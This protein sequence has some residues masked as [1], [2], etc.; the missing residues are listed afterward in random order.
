MAFIPS[1]AWVLMGCLSSIAGASNLSSL[2]PPLWEESPGQ[3][4]DYEV[5]N[6]IYI[7]DPWVYTKRIGM[8][9]ILLNQTATYFAKF[10]PENEQN[11]L[12]GL[13]LQHGWQFRSGRLADP[14]R[15]TN[16]G[17][18]PDH[19]LCISVDSWWADLNYFLCAIP[20]LAAVD[21][22][23]IGISADQVTLVP[24][25]KD[26]LRFCYNV[27]DCRSSHPEMMNNW[28]A[29]YQYLKSP[30]TNFDD[31]LK[32]IWHAHT[33]S[34]EGALGDFEDRFLYYSIPEANFEKSWVLIVNYLAAALY[35]ATLVRT[36]DFQKVLPPQ[37][38][39]TMDIAPFIKDFT[40]IQNV[41]LY[42]LTMFKEVNES[43]GFSN[44]SDLYPSRWKES[45]TDFSDYSVQNGI[46]VIDAWLFTSRLGL[47]K[48]LLNKTAKYFTKFAP[49]NE[50][51][52]LWGLPLQLDWQ[53]KTGRLVDPT[54][55]AN[56]VHGPEDLC[57]SVDSWWAVQ[58]IQSPSS[59]FTLILKYLWA[60]HISSLKNSA[61]FFEDRYAHYSNQEA[62]FMKNWLIAVDYLALVRFPTT[63]I[64]TREFQKH[65][66]PRILVS[67]DSAIFIKDFTATQ[68][69]VLVVLSALGK[70]ERITGL[71]DFLKK[72]NSTLFGHIF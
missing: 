9:K 53:F 61:K 13:P 64:K 55:R 6:G 17:Y 68:N 32:H 60:A 44:L 1:W 49:E 15:R 31:I 38:L 48:I 23:I 12:W 47:Y 52:V 10:A 29:F 26:Q 56:C 28:T 7:I 16:C 39:L 22:G 2:Y 20:F 58:Y 65:L 42:S 24:P 43:T 63:L 3:L 35:P 5:E 30:S 41:V 14:T 50:Q 71:A 37:V 21:S 59:T 8:Y 4:S 45:P 18:E 57:L 46:Y 34:L 62:D 66:P 27:S 69:S 11:L 51:N 19:H 70:W 54:K 33:S 67:T 72:H 36:Y 40:P 25:P